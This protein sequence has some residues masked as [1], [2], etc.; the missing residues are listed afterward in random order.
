V[1][2]NRDKRWRLGV[3]VRY[4]GYTA[5]IG[6]EDGAAGIGGSYQFLLTRVIK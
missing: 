5:A 2:G 3:G 1:F 6:R 4:A